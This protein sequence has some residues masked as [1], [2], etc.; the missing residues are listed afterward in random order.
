MLK[1][2][3]WKEIHHVTT[4]PSKEPVAILKTDKLNQIILPGIEKITS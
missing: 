2:K 4:N 1:V 3:E